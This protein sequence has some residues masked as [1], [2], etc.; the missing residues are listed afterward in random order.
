MGEEEEGREL[1]FLSPPTPPPRCFFFFPAHISLRSPHDLNAWNRLRMN[2]NKSKLVH[3]KNTELK[4]CVKK[5]Y[6]HSL[7]KFFMHVTGC[8][9]ISIPLCYYSHTKILV[10]EN[11]KIFQGSV[12]SASF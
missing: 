1:P 8:K 7:C 6:A 12:D 5:A 4:S 2:F 3:R 11:G 10:I 9:R